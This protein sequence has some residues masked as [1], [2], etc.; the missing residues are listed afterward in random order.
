[1]SA[2]TPTQVNELLIAVG[3]SL[4]QYAAE[5]YPWSPMTKDLRDTILRLAHQQQNSVRK[6]VHWLDDEGETLDYGIYP[7]DYT[8]LHY[9]S[10]AFFLKHMITNQAA[11]VELATVECSEED[12]ETAH[13]LFL[14]EILANEQAILDELRK[15]VN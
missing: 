1:M 2:V 10:A 14:A 3:R 8:S 11:I 6:I 4:L 12:A 15:L 5:A 7:V 13:H 9:V